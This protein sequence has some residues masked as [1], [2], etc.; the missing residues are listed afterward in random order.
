MPELWPGGRQLHLRHTMNPSSFFSASTSTSSRKRHRTAAG[1]LINSITESEVVPDITSK[2]ASPRTYAPGQGLLDFD[3]TSGSDDGGEDEVG[4][5][6]NSFTLSSGF[7][8]PNNSGIQNSLTPLSRS[9]CN[10]RPSNNDMAQLFSM[11]QQ[12]QAT[13]MQHGEVLKETL[14][15]QL[16]LSAKVKTFEK[17]LASL[18][19]KCDEVVSGQS[20]EP[21]KKK[22]KVSRDVS[23]S[24]I[25][26]GYCNN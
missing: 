19:N 16:A 25:E 17:K 11:L 6:D 9:Q 26:F 20:G 3:I 7:S 5:Q 24:C 14:S 1:R 23:V 12:Q 15:N 21:P 10:T 8:T 13:L 22:I 18:D 2:R 4:Y